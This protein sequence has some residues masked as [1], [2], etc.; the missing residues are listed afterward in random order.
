MPRA[1]ATEVSTAE[2]DAVFALADSGGRL[3]SRAAAKTGRKQKT[4]AKPKKARG[5][6]PSMWGVA[7]K[8]KAGK[9][10]VM[11]RALRN[12]RKLKKIVPPKRSLLKHPASAARPSGSLSRKSD[13]A[14]RQS[15]FKRRRT[16]EKSVEEFAEASNGA[17]LLITVTKGGVERGGRIRVATSGLF[18]GIED[19]PM[20]RVMAYIVDRRLDLWAAS[21]NVTVGRVL[22]VL[23]SG[24]AMPDVPEEE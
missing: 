7:K 8:T 15:S 12:P 22:A 16:L 23:A 10:T 20:N 17:A 19:V 5:G 1:S 14:L 13:D 9:S 18:Q 3:A 2:V 11:T 6:A 24:N 21:E 4:G